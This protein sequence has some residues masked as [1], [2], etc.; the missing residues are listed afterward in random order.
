MIK[1]GDLEL[2]NNL[3]SRLVW[4]SIACISYN[5]QLC[6]LALNV[7]DHGI[8]LFV[9]NMVQYL[10]LCW[11]CLSS[12]FFRRLCCLSNIHDLGLKPGTHVQVPCIHQLIGLQTHRKEKV[13]KI[14]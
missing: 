4:L 1:L 14:F 13:S 2:L 9:F 3:Q 7:H 6:A 11:L 10:V 5:V 8:L 12:L